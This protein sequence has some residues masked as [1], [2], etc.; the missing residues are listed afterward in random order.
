MPPPITISST[1]LASMRAIEFAVFHDGIRYFERQFG[2]Q[3]QFVVAPDHESQPGIR[4]L[5][6]I[7][8]L[9]EQNS[10]AC[11]LEDINTSMATVN[12][13]LRDLPVKRV[14]IDPLGDAIVADK[15]GYAR[16]LT[17]LA[18]A[19]DTCMQAP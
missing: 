2:L 15:Q 3:N 13:V 18:D 10:P 7:Q 14:P 4:H 1:R 16:L 12:T 8:A 11:L 5:M 6:E 17:S 9:I 19:F